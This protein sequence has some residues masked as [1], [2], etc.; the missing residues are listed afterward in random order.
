MFTPLETTSDARTNGAPAAFVGYALLSVSVFAAGVPA[1]A[2]VVLAYVKRASSP[3][4]VRSHFNRQIV[5]FWI[6]TALVGIAVAMGAATVV[7]TA[8]RL[9]AV[10]FFGDRFEVVLRPQLLI[11]IDPG[12][13]K[14]DVSAS[15]VALFFGTI[16]SSA[17]AFLWL[18]LAPIIGAIGLARAT[19]FSET[20]L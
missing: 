7:V 1:L 8:G 9:F 10:S 20:K 3:N 19:M 4:L 14:L 2:A 15:A 6:A 11:D 17:V 18:F 5:I 16:L 13:G 12:L